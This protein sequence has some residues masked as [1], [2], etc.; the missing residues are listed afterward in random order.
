ML[1][2]R[3]AAPGF[4]RVV[5]ALAGFAALATV[6]VAT[7]GVQAQPKSAP[8]Q[9][10]Q[11]QPAQ[12]AGGVVTAIKQRGHVICGVAGDRPGF[13]FPDSKGVVRGMD[14]DICRSVAAAIL[15]S[16]EKV[17]FVSLTSLTRFP[18]LQSGEVDIVARFTTWTLGREASLGLEVPAV[19]FYDGQGFLVKKSAGVK[20]ALDLR[21]ASVCFQPGSTGEA[22]VADYFR[23]N[24]LELKPVVI[25]KIEQLRDALVS[26]RCDAYTN[27]SAQLG[28]FKQSL[29]SAGNDYVVLPEIISKEP[30]GAFIRKGDQRF[31]DIV[32]WTHIATLTAEEFG[33]TQSNIDKF[34]GNAN[35]AIQRFMGE[36]GDLG[37]ALGLDPQWAVNVVKGVGNFSE[38]WERNI[39]PLGLQR[40]AN[41]LVKNG[42]IQYAPPMR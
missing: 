25:E 37:A 22:N 29:G 2:F 3:P 31:F 34:K 27:D 4:R 10:D 19:H 15:G 32:R 11:V 28:S 24:K 12:A 16:P 41:R 18:A 26:G 5:R 7:T 13:S 35:P 30:L 14:A 8:A 40:G 42:G 23:A 17:R 1:T 38:M 33:M 9:P 20:S 36:N 39:T 21:G 6:A